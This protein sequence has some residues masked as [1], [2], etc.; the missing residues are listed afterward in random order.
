MVRFFQV[1]AATIAPRWKQMRLCWNADPM[2][3]KRRKQIED[4]KRWLILEQCQVWLAWLE[5]PEQGY[6]SW[7]DPVEC[8]GIVITFCSRDTI[9]I[10]AAAGQQLKRW[11]L[12][13]MAQIEEFGRSR[14]CDHIHVYLRRGWIQELPKPW[15]SRASVEI[16][17]DSELLRVLLHAA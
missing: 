8:I 11:F 9:T 6:L 1:T 3:R 2:R 5:T 12:P 10:Q 13:A 17:H 7:T 16:F 15:K 14:C 4:L